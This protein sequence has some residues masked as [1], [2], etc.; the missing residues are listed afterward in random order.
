[1]AIVFWEDRRVGATPY[2]WNFRS[3]G[4]L[5]AKSPILNRYSLDPF[6]LKCWVKVTTLERNRRFSICF[7][8][9][10]TLAKKVQLTLIGSP[11][12]VFQWGWTSYIVSKPPKLVFIYVL[13]LFLAIHSVFKS[14]FPSPSA[15]NLAIWNIDV[16][17]YEQE[18][19][20]SQPYM[21]KWWPHT[22]RLQKSSAVNKLLTGFGHTQ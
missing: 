5:G 4:P 14:H 12:R 9:A 2:T 7:H 11:L 13:I 15:I 22:S 20:M 8:S 19:R 18:Q 6:Y 16:R 3:T 1:V 17:L 10:V 21:S